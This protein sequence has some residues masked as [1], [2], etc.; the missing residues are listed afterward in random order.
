MGKALDAQAD[1]GAVI[2][3]GKA[4]RIGLAQRIAIGIGHVRPHRDGVG[5]LRF[6]E[7]T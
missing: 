7:P 6:F 5:R 4:E 3:G 1:K 2:A